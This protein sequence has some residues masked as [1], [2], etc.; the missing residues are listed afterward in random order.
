MGTRMT[1]LD[2]ALGYIARRWAPIPIPYR[3]KKPILNEW[4][5]LRIGGPTRL[6]TSTAPQ[7]R[8]CIA[9]RAERQSG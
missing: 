5:K 3:K 9:G 4:K 7:E 6:A 2:V 1:P 8:R